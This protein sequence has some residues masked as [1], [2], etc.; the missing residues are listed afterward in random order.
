MVSAILVWQQ[1]GY[2]R[3]PPRLIFPGSL[4]LMFRLIIT[5]NDYQ[6]KYFVSYMEDAFHCPK[7]GRTLI[8]NEGDWPQRDGPDVVGQKSVT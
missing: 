6:I 3:P 2:V 5:L 1:T 7:L 4:V 8:S